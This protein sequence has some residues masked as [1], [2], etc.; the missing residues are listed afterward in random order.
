MNTPWS[1]DKLGEINKKYYGNEGT[2]KKS[3]EELG[4]ERV[5]E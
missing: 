3:L 1:P 5:S 2:A 4:N